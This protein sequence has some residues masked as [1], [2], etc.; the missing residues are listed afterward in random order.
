MYDNLVGF[1]RQCS[2]CDH[3]LDRVHRKGVEALLYS[4]VYVCVKCRNRVG[5]NRLVQTLKNQFTFAFSLYSRCPSCGGEDSLQRLKKRDRIDSRSKSPLAWIQH[6]LGA[7]VVRCFPCRL[8]Y[9][10]WRPLKG[11]WKKKTRKVDKPT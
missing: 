6:L 9:Y 11:D 2:K 8:Q 5:Y 4:D 7:P 1:S 10:D 3:R